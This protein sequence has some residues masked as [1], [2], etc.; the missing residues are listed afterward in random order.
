MSDTN[1]IRAQ[2]EKLIGDDPTLSDPTRI[3][4]QV[5]RVGPLFKKRL[6]VTLD[7]KVHTEFERRKVEQII[8][9]HFGDT[10]TLN[11]HVKIDSK[12]VEPVT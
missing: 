9:D 1:A 10:V 2:V 11:N 6:L 7:G 4:A 8:R 3:I 5:S 12:T